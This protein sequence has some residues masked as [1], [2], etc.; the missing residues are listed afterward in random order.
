MNHESGFMPGFS[1]L[2]GNVTI[3][4]RIIDEEL[5]KSVPVRNKRLLI[6]QEVILQQRPGHVPVALVL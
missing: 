3:L 4:K 5:C 1:F 2:A 6:S